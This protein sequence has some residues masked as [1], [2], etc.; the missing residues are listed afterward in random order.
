MAEKQEQNAIIK[1]VSIDTERCLSAWLTLDYGGSGQGFGGYVLFAPPW[2]EISRED[3]QRYLGNYTGVFIHRC[4]EIG[5]VGRWEDL[6][7][8]TIRVRH[9]QPYGKILAIGH[10]VKDDWFNPETEFERIRYMMQ[11]VVPK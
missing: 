9:D 8:K 10:I 7:G 4:I 2:D 1:S 6:P 3:P 11:E 5:G